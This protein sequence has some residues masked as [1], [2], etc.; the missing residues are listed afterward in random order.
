MTEVTCI[1]GD[2]EYVCQQLQDKLNEGW[3][4]MEMHTN[5][6]ETTAGVR[7]DTTVYLIKNNE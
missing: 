6:Y 2:S 7:R 1:Y 5:L 4:V 3:A